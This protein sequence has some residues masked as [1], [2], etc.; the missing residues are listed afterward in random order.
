MKPYGGTIS[1]SQMGS[2]GSAHGSSIL[3]YAWEAMGQVGPLRLAKRERLAALTGLINTA[4]AGRSRPGVSRKICNNAQTKP[5][6]AE[7]PARIIFFGSTGLCFAS[8]GGLTKYNHAA[9]QSC[10][11]HGKGYCGASA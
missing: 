4:P 8:G 2:A 1:C 6:P 10:I 5:P 7:S 9:R 3:Q 11:A